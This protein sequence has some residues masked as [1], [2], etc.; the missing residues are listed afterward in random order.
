MRAL[1][2]KFYVQQPH[3]GQIENIDCIIINDIFKSL[4]PH[5][6]ITRTQ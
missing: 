6:S 4:A 1:I 2:A 5:I 3:L